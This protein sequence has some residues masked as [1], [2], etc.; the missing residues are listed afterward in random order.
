MS[1]TLQLLYL[2]ASV[3]YAC[4]SKLGTI[5]KYYKEARIQKPKTIQT[6]QVSVKRIIVISLYWS[7]HTSI[8]IKQC[9][10]RLENRKQLLKAAS[11]VRLFEGNVFFF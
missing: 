1:M 8:W 4:A 3:R 9:W 7:D 10:Q 6:G 5:E 11:T 2:A